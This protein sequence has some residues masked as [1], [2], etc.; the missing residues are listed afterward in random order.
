MRN[1][2]RG[3]PIICLEKH[4]EPASY[5]CVFLLLTIITKATINVIAII[6]IPTNPK[7]SR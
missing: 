5:R 6:A 2:K 4:I 7:K 1:H 3:L